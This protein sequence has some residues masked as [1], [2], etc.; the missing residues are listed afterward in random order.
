MLDLGGM[1]SVHIDPDCR[2]ARIR[3]G[4][5]SG[6]LYAELERHQLHFP[7]GHISSVGCTGFSL[8]GGV[9]WDV[10]GKGFA[11]DNLLSA[12]VAIWDGEVD[13][14]GNNVANI[15]TASPSSHPDLFWGIRG[16]GQF[17]GV[18]TELE[19]QLHPAPTNIY[20]VAYHMPLS[21][22]WNAFKTFC[23]VVDEAPDSLHSQFVLFMGQTHA[24]FSDFSADEVDISAAKTC[25]QDHMEDFCRADTHC[26]V[27]KEENSRPYLEETRS[28]NGLGDFP[29]HCAYN[30]SFFVPLNKVNEEFWEVVVDHFKNASSERTAI[31]TAPTPRRCASVP[32]AFGDR[33]GMLWVEVLTAWERTDGGPVADGDVSHI[34][35]AHGIRNDLE[36]WCYVNYLNN[37]MFNSN[38]DGRQRLTTKESCFF[39]DDWAKLKEVKQKYDPHG[40]LPSMH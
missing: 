1:R 22:T 15:V 19:L 36:P 11:C 7:G 23:R 28:L 13:E 35:W 14:K 8:G 38:R 2:V 18:V 16:G 30:F 34:E 5:R 39:P 9:G 24:S 10:R 3:P 26:T 20:S 6:E 17:L 25:L 40:I 21:A 4:V 32:G 12:R 27:V 33:S 37:N 31:V 29:G